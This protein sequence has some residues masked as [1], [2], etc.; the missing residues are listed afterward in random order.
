M[1]LVDSLDHGQGLSDTSPLVFDAIRFVAHDWSRR[2]WLGQSA[3]WACLGSWLSSE[4][5]LITLCPACQY[6]VVQI[7]VSIYRCYLL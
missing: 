1:G 4:P 2:R 5:I 6:T 3:P 7:S